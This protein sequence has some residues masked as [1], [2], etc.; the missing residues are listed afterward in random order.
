MKVTR[1]HRPGRCDYAVNRQRKDE[2]PVLV[3]C[4]KLARWRVMDPNTNKPIR[5]YCDQHMRRANGE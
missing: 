5:F 1:L 4:E 3:R 2:D